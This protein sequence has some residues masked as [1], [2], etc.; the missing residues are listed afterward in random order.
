MTRLHSSSRCFA[1]VLTASLGC[2]AEVAGGT[3]DEQSIEH[4]TVTQ[5]LTQGQRG[6][7]MQT[8]RLD[9]SY[10][11]GFTGSCTGALLGPRTVLT[12]GHCVTAHSGSERTAGVV[13]VFANEGTARP[14]D[15]EVDL[16]LVVPHP[17]YPDS[18]P[19][20][21]EAYDVALVGLR[22]PVALPIE[23][24][25]WL[26]MPDHCPEHLGY[27]W[28]NGQ[29]REGV[30]SSD[31]AFHQVV[32]LGVLAPDD[33]RYPYQ[34]LAACTSTSRACEIQQ[35]DSGGPLFREIEGEANDGMGGGTRPRVY[36]VVSRIAS[37]ARL[38]PIADWIEAT[39]AA[40]EDAPEGDGPT[41]DCGEL[42]SI[43]ACNDH[44]AA[45]AWYSCSESCHPRGTPLHVA[46]PSP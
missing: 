26:R 12:A 16:S 4:E 13:H 2:A 23:G 25:P 24:T 21:S 15:V 34:L 35:G 33:S 28:L 8:V 27:M 7:L 29:M 43:F 42:G 3:L 39:Y 22:H 40:I 41:V 9:I 5:A 14:A 37:Y 10:A 1:L 18:G 36:G 20:P 11:E 38:D 19:P 46:C 6:A 45:C 30:S 44:S 32:Q 17:T 31:T